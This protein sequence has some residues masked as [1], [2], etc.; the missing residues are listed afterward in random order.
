MQLTL[1][2]TSESSHLTRAA[3]IRGREPETWLR[4]M[5]RWGLAA[6]ELACYVVPESL[7]SLRPAGLFVIFLNR[8]KLP[9]SEL[10]EP[11][12]VIADRLYV[13]VQARLYPVV[14]EAELKEMLLWERQLFHPAIGLVGFCTQDALDLTDLLMMPAPSHTLWNL[15]HPGLPAR[16]KLE[17]I[18]LQQP[19]TDELTE[20]FQELIQTEPLE[21]IPGSRFS[22][23]SLLRSVLA[24]LAVIPMALVWLI[25]QLVQ[26][27]RG[28]KPEDAPRTSQPGGGSQS[29]A[30]LHWLASWIA[31]GL[32]DIQ[33]KRNSEI[34]RLLEL[35]EKNQDEA[36]KYA[37]PLDSPYQ[38]RGQAAPGTS[39]FRRL[40]N[41]DFRK[42]GGGGLADH[43]NVDAFYPDLRTKYFRAAQKALETKD[44]RKAAYIYAHLLGDFVN[45]AKVLEQGKYFREAAALHKK[46]LNNL[47]AAAECLERGGLL[48]E[49]AGIYLEL[50]HHEKAGD[51][52]R[53]MNQH[54]KAAWHYE[55]SCD[56]SLSNGDY[57][58]AARIAHDKLEQTDRANQI[59]LK[60]WVSSN[61]REACLK[62][63]LEGMASDEDMISQQV[64]EIF[65]L[66]TPKAQRA[67][68]LHVLVHLND[69][70][71]H[72]R[73]QDTSR[74]LAYEIISEEAGEGNL[75]NLYTLKKFLPEDQLIA[76][77]C[78]RYATENRKNVPRTP[79]ASEFFLDQ[80]TKWV[81][82]V[83]FRNQFLAL[84]IRD[85][86]L[87]LARGN[88]YGNFEYYSWSNQIKPED[89]FELVADPRYSHQLILHVA[90]GQVLE[91][92]K[93]PKNKYF[94]EALEVTCPTW[95]VKGFSGFTFNSDGGL[96]TLVAN[97]HRM[98]LH[99]YSSK[100]NLARSV[101]CQFE[102]EPAFLM[103][104]SSAR[105]K[106]FYSEDHYYTVRGNF[107]IKIDKDGRSQRY[108][109]RTAI[110]RFAISTHSPTIK[111]ALAFQREVFLIN[112]KFEEQ[113][114]NPRFC[115]QEEKPV[116][117]LQFVSA[118]KL[119][120]TGQNQAEVYAIETTLPTLIQTMEARSPIVAIL[121][122]THR[123]K[124]AF[125]EQS[126]RIAICELE[127]E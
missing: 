54:V 10:L 118:D 42:L 22:M 112:E 104:H 41:F 32:E 96:S 86:H 56:R 59:L 12:G 47:P 88:W 29:P 8:E 82:A 34:R 2:L 15:A 21:E 85:S 3:F 92:K 20:F 4:E 81:S 99:H 25:Q 102:S 75:S 125:L 36:L 70:H 43:W 45:A 60:G 48:T 68:F 35:F 126:G 108:Q 98:S 101:N 11:Y 49:A 127:N 76:G 26:A 28:S 46:Y 5:N 40:T 78:S 115:V 30:W 120:V 53:R 94:D 19:P 122:P 89:T 31:R 71:P 37:I 107:L 18:R 114:I 103:S 27:I 113:V 57:L 97:A 24:L 77:D 117:N 123:F 74:S 124:V 13:P 121:T 80:R 91:E 95:L 50:H 72:A 14:C 44:F 55:Q 51:L 52:F 105:T 38:S 110:N 73:L 111:M 79:A 17:S 100:W 87:H 62:Q 119:V 83:C 90:S 6:H 64:Q 23:P 16:P 93:L 67:A 69:K 39:L 65:A 9:S 63:Y 106:M 33:S 66:H 61:Q 116:V 84:G 109:F 7:Q 1:Q 58:E